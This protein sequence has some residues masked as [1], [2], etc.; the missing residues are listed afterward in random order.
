M[1]L[2]TLVAVAVAG[3]LVPVWG[4][5]LDVK[6]KSTL[7]FDAEAAKERPVSKVVALLQK[8]TVELEKAAEYDEE[9]YDKLACWCSVN[10]KVV[11]AELSD[12][13]EKIAS[14]LS[15]IAE[16][17]A[18]STRL[19]IDITGL[20][21]EVAAYIQVL[22]TITQ[23]YMAGLEKFEHDETDMLEAIAPLKAAIST[24]SVH[25][26][27]SLLQMPRSNLKSIVAQLQKVI[28]NH[29][30]ALAGVLDSSQ[31]NALTSFVQSGDYFDAD[32]TF[33]QSYAPQSGVVLGVLKQ[34]LE[35]FQANLA[36]SQKSERV[37]V[38]E[39]KAVKRAKLIQINITN[40]QLDKKIV[41]FSETNVK[42]TE[43]KEL[44]IDTNKSVQEKEK[45][46]FM[47]KEK[48]ATADKDWEE[49]QKTRQA[50]MAAVAKALEI[51]NSGDA[52][53]LFTRT[54][55]PTLLQQESSVMSQQRSE[56]AKVLSAVAK[57]VGNPRL[58]MIA[59]NVKIDAFTKVKKAIDEM[60]GALQKEKKD[61]MK[62][63]DFCNG[64]LL[65]H[66]DTSLKL[67]RADEVA[68]AAISDLETSIS[69]FEEQIKSLKKEVAEMKE[70]MKEA[71]ESRVKE[72]AA[73][74]ET[75][76]D[77][78]QTQKVVASALAV[79]KKFYDAQAAAS[80]MQKKILLQKKALAKAPPPPPSFGDYRSSGGDHSQD[81]MDMLDRIIRDAAKMEDES[82]RDETRA[83][84]TYDAF[85]S[86]SQSTIEVKTKEMI[87][88]TDNKAKAEGDLIEAKEEKSMVM[89][90][91]EENEATKAKIDEACSFTLKN[92]EL[93]QTARD[94]EI[95]ALKQAKLILSGGSIQQ[96]LQR[97]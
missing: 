48:C 85:M 60:V 22:D 4:L 70:S 74:Q 47:L 76:A 6:M 9:L 8:M 2:A 93:R 25:H 67:K 31:K 13:D 12:A 56:A 54:F 51:L 77:Q 97:A 16:L 46:L 64:A 59:T 34:M 44:L 50:E 3:V 32:P 42:L 66:H 87:D 69:T 73:Y 28:Q 45:Y 24:L 1:K 62:K 29:N 63:K 95:E 37:R 96:F 27:E 75:V 72:N 86:E 58:A 65:E 5:N 23:I 17:T 61:E 35:T 71:T 94:Q 36:E 89:M 52:H 20:K 80:L 30:S 26:P 10:E 39:F 43:T 91:M 11:T 57:K 40:A 15:Y 82:T 88:V 53:D 79:L 92:F 38:V 19:N 68:N 18:T 33:K 83:Q 14:L 55:N 49:R 21:K 41:E 84:K 7:T 78:K 81:V 90:N